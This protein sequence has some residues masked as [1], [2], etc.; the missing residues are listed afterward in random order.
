M[1]RAPDA[2]WRVVFY[3]EEDASPVRDFLRGLDDKTRARFGWLIDRLQERNVTAREP[4]VRKLDDKLWELRC[5]SQT[6]IY[7]L[8]FSFVT[9]RRIVLLHGF[10]KKT[11]KTPRGEIEIAQSHLK[12]FIE[13]E[14]G[15]GHDAESGTRPRR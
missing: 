2:N 6:N 1:D 11:Q 7:R 14:G 12:R 10:Q 3:I 15:E 5:E 13:R 9:R 8:I 4:L